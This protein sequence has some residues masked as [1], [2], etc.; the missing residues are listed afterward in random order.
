M[1]FSHELNIGNII[2]ML[3]FLAAAVGFILSLFQMRKN[4]ST[5]RAQLLKDMFSP[6][7]AD[8]DIR[9]IFYKVLYRKFK[10]DENF[11][12]SVDE[13]RVDKLLSHFNLVC[14]FYRRKLISKSEIDFFA[15]Y[16]YFVFLNDE[17]Q[18]YFR[19][20]DS[21]LGDTRGYLPQIDRIAVFGVYRDYCEENM[22]EDLKKTLSR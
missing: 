4:A 12:S 5:Y 2:A 14:N 18:Q 17:K 9:K 11:H 13:M 3:V 1:T 10:Y 16:L 21:H 19:V 7:Y 6:M 20:L 8:E 15:C 22:S